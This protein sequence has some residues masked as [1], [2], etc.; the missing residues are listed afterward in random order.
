MTASDYRA[1]LARLSL[2][3][4]EAGEL[5]GVTKKTSEAW[6]QGARNIPQTVVLLLR[7]IEAVGLKKAR[8]LLE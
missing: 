2:N 4:R 5:L 6:A 7:L 8:K 3:Q 1:T